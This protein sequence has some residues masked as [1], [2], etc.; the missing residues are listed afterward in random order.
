VIVVWE[1]RLSRENGV[2]GVKMPF[3]T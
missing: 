3:F 2:F 1:H